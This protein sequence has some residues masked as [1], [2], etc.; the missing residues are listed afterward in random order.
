MPGAIDLDAY[1]ARIGYEGPCEATLDVLR[2]LHLKHAQTIP[3]ENLSSFVGVPV[4]I[5]VPSLE[6][7]LV[8]SRRG[9]YCFEQNA[10]FSAVLEAMGFEVTRL[11]ARVLW[12]VPEGVITG[13]SHMVLLIEIDGRDYVADVGFGGLTQTA[14]LLLDGREQS[15]PHEK[16]RIGREGDYY[17]IGAQAGGEWRALYRF[18]LTPQLPVDYTYSNYYV[19]TNP[20]SIFV[21]GLMLCRPHE[22]G[23]YTL[24]NRVFSSYA[25]D[26]TVARRELKSAD[27][28]IAVLRDLFLID[29][30]P[31]LEKAFAGLA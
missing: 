10:L 21:N 29:P 7:K 3:F 27:E 2:D 28:L 1:F 9:G 17:K 16:F 4:P 31:G 15:T 20:A 5:D 22:N 26:G 24:S 12:G 30:P 18:D 6:K 19:A 25:K 14:P 13:R 8:Q 23:R 11:A